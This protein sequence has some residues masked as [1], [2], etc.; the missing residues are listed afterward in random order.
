MADRSAVPLN[1]HERRPLRDDKSR[2]RKMRLA[3][4]AA[5][6]VAVVLIAVKLVAWIGTGS[7]ALLSTLV[8][9]AVDAV[10]SVL[11]L[12]AVHQ[13]L[14]PADRE[15]RFGH[16]KAEPLAGLGQS[17]FIAGSALFVIG[18][19]GKR[20][21]APEPVVRSGLGI[22]VMVVSI[23][24]TLVLLRF[25]RLVVR[26]TGSLAV[27]A[28]STHYLGDFLMNGAVVVGLVVQ[29]TL[30]WGLVDPLLAIVIA[31]V[32]L[33]S[34]WEISRNSLDLLMDHELP[35]A[36]R[37]RI[38]EIVSA[39]PEVRNVHDLR[40]RSTGHEFVHP[41]SPRTRPGHRPQQGACHQRRGR[42]SIRAAFPTAEV[43]IHQDPAG[44][45]E[46]RTEFT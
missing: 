29:S 42:N 21:F 39:H 46:E 44:V 22:A 17:A 20:L 13:A 25:Q 10:A 35:E 38:F 28:D 4:A 34:A 40:T 26:E 9:S 23:V 32:L 41:A 16:G 11:N 5:V 8:D 1:D 43:M 37:R 27:R 45:E 12:I 30:G 7:V 14:Q 31:L 33:R 36:D 2:G 24:L 19:A 6:A 15:H 3:T 18:E